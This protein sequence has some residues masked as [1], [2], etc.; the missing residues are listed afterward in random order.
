MPDSTESFRKLMQQGLVIPAHPLAL[1]E[2]G[3]LDVSGPEDR[4]TEGA[5]RFVVEMRRLLEGE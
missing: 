5:A 4:W 3:R 2:D 1:T